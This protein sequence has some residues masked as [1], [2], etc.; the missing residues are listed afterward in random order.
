MIVRRSF[1]VLKFWYEGNWCEIDYLLNMDQFENNPIVKAFLILLCTLI[2][3]FF[4]IASSA[5]AIVTHIDTIKKS[6]HR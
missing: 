1:M 5:S 3:L 6:A 2:I 4:K